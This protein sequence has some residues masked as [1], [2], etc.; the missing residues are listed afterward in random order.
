ML[1][2]G[3]R[4]DVHLAEHPLAQ[5]VTRQCAVLLDQRNQALVAEPFACLVDRIRNAIGIQH[6][7][8]ACR[9]RHGDL[10]QQAVERL[11]LVDLQPEH[12]PIGRQQ[13][14]ARRCLGRSGEVY[15]RTMAGPGVSQRAGFEIH[16]KVGHR[17]ETAA[18]ELLR[19]QAVGVDEQRPRRPVQL[20]QR[21][22]QSLELGHI[23]R[24]RRPLPRDV[25]DQHAQRVLIDRQEVV[26]VPADLA[27]RLAEGRELETGD[28]HGPLRQERHLD[29]PRHPQLLFEPFLLGLL[30]QQVLDAGRHQVEGLGQLAELVPPPD[31]DAV[32]EV[33]LPD[34][35]RA[36]KEVVDRSRDRPREPQAHAK[37][38]DLDDQEQAADHGHKRK[39]ELAEIERPDPD[40]RSARK[41]VVH[42]RHIHAEL[43]GD[44]I[45]L[46]RGPVGVFQERH[47]RQPVISLG[48]RRGRAGDDDAGVFP[49]VAG[50]HRVQRH[51]DDHRAGR[52]G[53]VDP[54]DAPCRHVRK[55]G[56]L[57]RDE[58]R[59]AVA[60]YPHRNGWR[61]RQVRPRACE[62]DAGA[63]AVLVGRGGD[64]GGAA[65]ARAGHDRVRD[66]WVSHGGRRVD[67]V[68]R[69]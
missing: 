52:T 1:S 10:L 58:A 53:R 63:S 56:P 19:Q 7:E 69:G 48:R 18:I 31:G 29:V 67:A 68:E 66:R 6:E 44:R 39:Q 65:R 64:R 22:H 23:E 4:E 20:A 12:Q 41:A 30:L 55:A 35:Y 45:R 38:H 60:R 16:D 17:D 21:Q 49:Q 62:D 36:R 32:R 2:G 28:A 51:V 57:P 37:R 26:I 43:D 9:D 59:I 61:R 15:Q 3:S 27:R 34:P 25:G 13:L 50:K 14:R 8:V 11:P 46:A 33:A 54:G 42:V 5:L 24:G 47:P 40:Q